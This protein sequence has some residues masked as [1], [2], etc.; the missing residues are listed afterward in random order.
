MTF[1]HTPY[2]KPNDLELERFAAAGRCEH[3]D[4]DEYASMTGNLSDRDKVN[5]LQAHSWGWLMTQRV[6]NTNT[7]FRGRDTCWRIGII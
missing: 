1:L 4:P 6:T 3:V 2:V 5:N 7:G